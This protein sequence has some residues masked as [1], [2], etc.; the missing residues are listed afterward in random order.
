MRFPSALCLPPPLAP[1]F[2][3]SDRPH[4]SYCR[5]PA[6][7]LAAWLLSSLAAPAGDAFR[8]SVQYLIDNSRSVFDRPQKVS[9]R[10][11]R[12][13]AASP[14][15]KYLYAGYLHSFN[16]AGEVRRLAIG[17]ADYERATVSLLPGPLG[18]AIAT[19]DRGRVYIASNTI[20]LIYD[21]L[22]RQR[23]YELNTDLCDGVTTARE[24]ND[25]ILYTTDREEGTVS[26]YLVHENGDGIS[27]VEPNGYDGTGIFKLPQALDLRGLKADGKGHLWIADHRGNRLYK[28]STDGKSVA[29]VPVNMPMDVA[30]ANDRVFVTRDLDRAVTVLDESLNVL[31]NLAV[32]WEELELSPFGN[33]RHGSLAGVVAIPGK[34]LFVA[35][36]GGQTANQRSTYGRVDEHTDI[37]NGKVFRD[38]FADDND[39]ILH[40][41]E[42]TTEP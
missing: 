13:L 16:N 42:V 10:H 28:M 25:L 8:W 24:G 35:N 18:K 29:S 37:I 23:L 2:R 11:V 31:G 21:A 38:A 3:P 19:D 9:P 26:R 14:D 7:G 12:G 5:L 17:Q 40:A 6:L 15:G 4:T 22:L 36:E 39:P 41:S 32:P 33:N 27:L 34:G 20:I 1:V 30:L